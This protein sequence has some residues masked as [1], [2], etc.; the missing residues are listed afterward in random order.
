MYPAYTYTQEYFDNNAQLLYS[1]YGVVQHSGGMQGGHYTAYVKTRTPL[2]CD[3]QTLLSFTHS[4]S[5]NQKTGTQN[6]TSSKSDPTEFCGSTK[7][8]CESS[9]CV[10]DH[11]TESEATV[12]VVHTEVSVDITESDNVSESKNSSSVGQSNV[13]E[14]EKDQID[15]DSSFCADVSKALNFDPSMTDGQW[16]YISDSHVKTASESEVLR[17]QAYL[18]FYERLPLQ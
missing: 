11:R 8:E 3:E 5:V 9:G 17:C 12:G 1:L 4:S 2:K 14:C 7:S 6:V 15:T 16:Y 13:V 10:I 18:L